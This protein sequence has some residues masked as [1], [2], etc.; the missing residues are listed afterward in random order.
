[1]TMLRT[2]GKLSAVLFLCLAAILLAGAR[3]EVD[4][5]LL[6]KGRVFPNI[7]PGL[8]AIRHGP[9]GK[10]Y[11]LASPAVG[12]A[13]FDSSGKQL[14]VIDAPPREPAADKTGQPAMGFGEDCDVDPKGDVY[15]A[16]RGSNLINLFSPDGKPVR[17]F[18]VNAPTS[19][20][21]LP[22]GE[23][24]V[25]SAMQTHL[26]TV[27]GPNGRVVREFGSPE[28]L[29][30]REDLNRYLSIGRLASDSQGRVY[31]GYTYMPEPLVRQYDRFGYAG[32][33]FQFTGLDAY[34]EAQVTRKAIVEMEKEEKRKGPISLRQILT[35]FGVD[36]VNGD[37]WMALHNTLIHFDKEAN[38]RSEYQIYTPKG[39]RLEAN[40]ILVEEERLL[41]GAD[42][43]GVYEFPRPDRA[44]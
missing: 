24:A 43:L 30:D 32:L 18:P 29:S 35:A 12:V 22:E 28:S 33:D 5:Q 26:I 7:G 19:L 39:A 44:H 2:T 8:R 27:Y 40:T 1:M 23:V 42:P 6:A 17:S 9:N 41:I 14:E 13:V 38:R 3:S 36:P 16:D 4:E 11:I 20:V 15:V 34:P 10:Y 25:T 31:Y 21:A 37:V